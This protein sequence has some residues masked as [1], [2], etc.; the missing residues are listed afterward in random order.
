MNQPKTMNH[1]TTD[2][3]PTALSHLRATI[4]PG[5]A[6]CQVQAVGRRTTRT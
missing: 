6:R 5:L 3:L 1:L 4:V 2:V